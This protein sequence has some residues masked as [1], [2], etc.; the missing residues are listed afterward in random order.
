M[1]VTPFIA[2]CL[3]AVIGLLVAVLANLVV[4]PHVLRAQDEGFV[5]GRKTV[6]GA[7]NQEKVAQ[8]T[9]FMY[10]ILMPVLF[11][12]VGWFAGLKVFGE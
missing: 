8:L 11:A 5:M 12:F 6:L 1:V 3:G 10:R 7:D 2:G 9:R 4:L